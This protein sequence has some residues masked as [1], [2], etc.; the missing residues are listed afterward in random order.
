[1]DTMLANL[2]AQELR[3]AAALKERIEALQGELNRLIGGAIP[4]A[5][6]RMPGRRRMSRAAKARIGAAQKAR[7]AAIKAKTPKKQSARTGRKL[8]AAAREHLAAIARA[9]WKKARAEGRRAL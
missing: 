6:T 4:V 5:G 8:S 9:R 7:W 3:R 1:M 2:S